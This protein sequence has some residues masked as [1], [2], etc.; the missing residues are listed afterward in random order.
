MSE[1]ELST[2]SAMQTGNPYRTYK[3]TVLGR[4]YVSVIDPFSEQPTGILLYGDPKR[5]D[6]SCFI[7]MWSERDDLFFK[8]MNKVHFA[9]GYIIES[10]RP[11]KVQVEIPIEQYSDEQLKGVINLKF[12]ALQAKL[13]KIESEAVLL[14]MVDIAENIEKSA[15]IIRAIKARL[16]EIQGTEIK[17]E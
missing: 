3:K 10:P 1:N 14:R 17:S 8:K 12:L 16:S 11:E 4:V 15:A 13:N 5:G 7:D 6:E 9:S 2:Y